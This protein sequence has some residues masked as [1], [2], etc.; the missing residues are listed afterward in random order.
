MI[1]LHGAGF[2]SG[3]EWSPD[4]KKI[5]Y[6]DNSQTILVVDVTTGQCAKKVGGNRVYTPIGMLSTPGR[7]IPAGWPTPCS[8][9]RW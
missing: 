7:P 6:V 9:T 5:A 4:G 2:Y 8:L 3:L 1:E